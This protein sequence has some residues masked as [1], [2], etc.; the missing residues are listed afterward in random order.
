MLVGALVAGQAM[1][2]AGVKPET[3]AAFD[4]YAQLTEQRMDRELKEG[5]FLVLGNTSRNGIV[6]QDHKND[7][8]DVPHGQI[9][10]WLGGVFLPGVTL[11]QVAAIKQDYD[12]YKDIYKPDVMESRLI[13]RNGDEFELYL[14]I[15]KKQ[16]LTVIYD[17][18]YTVRYYSPEPR[19]MFLRSY[20]TKI[21]EVDK[22]EGE[23]RGFLWRLNSYW[24]LQEADGG[25]YVECEAVSLSRD[26]PSFLNLVVGSFI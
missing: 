4:K 23:D 9:H 24:R 17:T 5:H 10:H 1:L 21:K 7:S 15:Y 19:K 6:V 2:L 8:V 18:Y 14:K 22:P 11:A 13:K 12:H 26:V 20:A 16:I 25:V 3:N